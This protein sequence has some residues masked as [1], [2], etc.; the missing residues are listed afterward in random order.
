MAVALATLIM[1]LANTVV[2]VALLRV[3]AKT[4]KAPELLIGLGL[5]G[6]GPVSQLFSILAG[7][8]RVPAGEVNLVL[9]WV[10]ISGSSLGLSCIFLFVWRVFRP[11]EAWA[12]GLTLSAIAALIAVGITNAVSMAT[13]PADA[14]SS[15]ATWL[16]GMM[17]LLLFTT[18][19]GWAAI[20]AGLYYA[21]LRK[22]V[23]L[24]LVEPV[25]SNRFLLWSISTGAAALLGLFLSAVHGRGEML[26]MALVPSLAICVVSLV[27]GT[28]MYLAFLPPRAYLSWVQSRAARSPV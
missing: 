16:T 2:G 18:A 28:G 26:T 22:Q 7:V 10:S 27:T 14:P 8:G 15:E 21:R 24:G 6:M 13:A 12:A 11:T 3:A 9:H 1:I 25:V 20:E 5:L 19:F 23:V 17:V 4:R